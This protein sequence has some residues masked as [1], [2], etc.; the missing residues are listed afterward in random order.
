M[1]HLIE[2]LR[3]L[4]DEL[5]LF[6]EQAGYADDAGYQKWLD[7][8]GGDITIGDRRINNGDSITDDYSYWSKRCPRCGRNSMQVVRPGKV[9]CWRCG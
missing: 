9:Q 2:F 8:N 1:R 7:E 3:L 4:R 5:I 6:W